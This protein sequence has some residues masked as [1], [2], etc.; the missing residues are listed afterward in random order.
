MK[1][2]LLHTANTEPTALTERLTKLGHEVL[3]MNFQDADVAV[4]HPD[5]RA[6]TD[7]QEL[8]NIV[9]SNLR[10]SPIPMLI[11]RHVSDRGEEFAAM[12]P[13]L[14]VLDDTCTD[15]LLRQKLLETRRL[16]GE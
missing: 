12:Y 2:F 3:R 9:F 14:G 8:L 13:I 11:V 16:A 5:A 1:V 10:K 6:P 15:E 4:L 7:F